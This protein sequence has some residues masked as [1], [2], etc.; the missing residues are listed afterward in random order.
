[1]AIILPRNPLR[2]RLIT[3]IKCVF[4]ATR[5]FLSTSHTTLMTRDYVWRKWS[6][7]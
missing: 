2:H 5:T 4:A 3:A 7:G 1:M 6:S